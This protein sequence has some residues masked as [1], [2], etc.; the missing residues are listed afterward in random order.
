MSTHE[1]KKTLTFLESIPVRDLLEEHAGLLV[2]GK[3]EGSLAV[4]C[5]KNGRERKKSASQRTKLIT[6]PVHN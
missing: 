1:D 2:I 5:A 4:L 6:P 3:G